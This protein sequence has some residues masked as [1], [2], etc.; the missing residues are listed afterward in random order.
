MP[1]CYTAAMRVNPI[2]VSLY[3]IGIAINSLG[4]IVLSP[5]KVPLG[6][7]LTIWGY[8]LWA[9]SYLY[10]CAQA[11]HLKRFNKHLAFWL[12]F[13]V[14]APVQFNAARHRQTVL[15]RSTK[16][17]LITLLV[18]GSIMETRYYLQ[19]RGAKSNKR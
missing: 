2:V 5:L 3:L 6:L 10:I 16:T 14:L 18:V 13:T 15:D 12:L 7:S 8:A 19:R 9:G 1:T 17:I 4:R 11:L